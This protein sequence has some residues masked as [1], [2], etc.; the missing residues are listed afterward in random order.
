M[1]AALHFVSRAITQLLAK[2][3]NEPEPLTP[4]DFTKAMDEAMNC[5]DF[6]HGHWQGDN[7]MMDQLER[8]GYEAA[9]EIFRNVTKWYA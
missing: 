3:Q 1:K 9:V 2:R 6:E 4:E 7:L 8:L 5:G